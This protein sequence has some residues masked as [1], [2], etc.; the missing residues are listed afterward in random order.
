MKET[1]NF[2]LEDEMRMLRNYEKLSISE[3][4]LLEI[5]IEKNGLDLILIKSEDEMFEVNL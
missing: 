1:E 5:N 2:K 3:K 4:V